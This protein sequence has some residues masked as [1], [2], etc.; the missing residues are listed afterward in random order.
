LPHEAFL[1]AKKLSWRK[2]MHQI[3]EEHNLKIPDDNKLV[4]EKCASK[5]ESENCFWKRFNACVHHSKDER[6]D[7]EFMH[8]FVSRK[9]F[10]SFSENKIMR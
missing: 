1:K 6:H 7:N 9:T 8:Y 10:G 2:Y 3:E 4:L 5:S